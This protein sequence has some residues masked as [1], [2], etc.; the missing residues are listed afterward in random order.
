MYHKLEHCNSFLSGEVALL[1]SACD[2][3]EEKY[4]PASQNTKKGEKIS[5]VSGLEAEIWGQKTWIVSPRLSL[6]EGLAPSAKA[7]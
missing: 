7:L 2:S 4:A 6:T 3:L 5:R 1:F